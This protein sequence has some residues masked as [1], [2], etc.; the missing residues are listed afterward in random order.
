M[1]GIRDL[2]AGKGVEADMLVRREYPCPSENRGF[3]RIEQLAESLRETKD[4]IA[5]ISDESL[6]E[7]TRTRRT[8]RL[9]ARAD[10]LERSAVEAA[11]L[12]SR[13]MINAARMTH[14]AIVARHRAARTA[15]PR[16]GL[17]DA[18]IR[19]ACPTTPTTVPKAKAG[20]FRLQK[21]ERPEAA[22]RL[23]RPCL[24]TRQTTELSGSVRPSCWGTNRCGTG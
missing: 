9:H 24:H 15:S 16:S 19:K 20:A 4:R 17:S 7:W 2:L 18:T 14:D 13:A 22:S 10:L 8:D 3:D 23:Y 1:D 6:D 12:A 21:W 5:S 11:D